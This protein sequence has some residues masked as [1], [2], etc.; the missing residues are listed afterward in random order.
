MTHSLVIHGLRRGQVLYSTV[1]V[2]VHYAK[3]Y[4]LGGL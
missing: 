4:K 3:M 2:L 1:L